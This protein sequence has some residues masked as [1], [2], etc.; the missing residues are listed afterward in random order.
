M[1]SLY[2]DRRGVELRLDGGAIAFYENAERIGTV[3]LAPLERVFLRGDVLLHSNLLGKLGEKNIGLVTLSGRRGEPTLL[4]ARPHNDAARRV[5]QYHLS[6]DPAFCLR[7]ASGL[8]TAKMAAAEKFLRE[9]LQSAPH[10]ARITLE[11]SCRR[12]DALAENI[13]RQSSPHRGALPPESPRSAPGKGGARPSALDALRGL[14]GKAAAI[15]F[16]ALAAYLPA[17]LKFTGRNRRPPRDPFN[18][19]LSL[20]YTLLHA[21]IVIA[22]YGAGLDPYIGFYHGLH[23]G[24]ESLASDLIE[25]LR[26]QYDRFAV[27]LFADGHLRPENF[28]IG[29]RGCLLGKA[30]RA[31]F[32]SL[33]EEAAEAFR[34]AA[35]RNVADLV[36]LLKQRGVDVGVIPAAMPEE[37]PREDPSDAAD[38]CPEGMWEDS[39]GVA[40]WSEYEEVA[41]H[42]PEGMWEDSEG[43]AAW[44]ECEEAAGHCPEEAWETDS[45]L[46]YLMCSK[47]NSV[48][49][50][51]DIGMSRG[52]Y[53]YGCTECGTEFDEVDIEAMIEARN[54]FIREAAE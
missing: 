46:K 6:R 13:K 23:F 3:P 24:R 32:Y 22:L 29:E 48:D 35:T 31:R 39:E 40:A 44:S 14:E 41:G 10:K 28:S 2:V 11:S 42:C 50:I 33:Y 30:G 18:A 43:V 36:T 1:S 25:P 9:L 53:R 21:D 16:E 12:L 27:G 7:I 26:P 47:C 19:V 4:L 20:G 37:E 15:Y 34:K 8:V 17:S 51:E 5:A 38:H 52:R 49:A 54:E 45:D